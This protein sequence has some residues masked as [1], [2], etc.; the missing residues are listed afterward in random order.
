MRQFHYELVPIG[1]QGNC[2]SCWAFSVTDVLADRAMIQTGGLW[3]K[4]LSVEQLLSCFNRAGCDGGSPELAMDWLAKTQTELKL[5]S[6]FPYTSNK[7]GL[8]TTVCPKKIEGPGII[9]EEGSVKSIVTFIDEKKYSRKILKENI[10]AMKTE[11]VMGG[12]FYAA[13]TVYDDFFTFA[14]TSVYSP[15]KGS[16]SVGGHAI[17]IIGYSEKGQ[18]PRKGFNKTPYWICR[19]SWSEGW[20]TQSVLPGYFMIEMGKNIC[21]IESRCGVATP[22]ILAKIPKHKARDLKELRFES[23]KDYI[24]S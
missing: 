8:V 1:N 11:L 9:V 3:N 20:P 19:N 16:R 6:R 15:G 13:M 12:P 14:G 2:G 22:Y 7:G 10:R 18:D 17:E 23:F 4:N 24:D 21:G 5:T